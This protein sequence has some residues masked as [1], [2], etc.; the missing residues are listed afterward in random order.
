MLNKDKKIAE[1]EEENAK[2]N[3]QLQDLISNSDLPI[4]KQLPNGEMELNGIPMDNTTPVEYYNSS[5]CTFSELT[6]FRVGKEVMNREM[7]KLIKSHIEECDKYK[8]VIKNLEF[9]RNNLEE[10]VQTLLKNIEENSNKS[11][12]LIDGYNKKLKDKEDKIENLIDDYNAKIE[13]YEKMINLLE[14][15]I[16]S[17]KQRFLSIQNVTINGDIETIYGKVLKN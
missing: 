15:D 13:R 11:K 7:D 3:K 6:M 12:S 2:L 8:N 10:N 4:I 14:D 17:W 16:N 5:K 9:D 1:L